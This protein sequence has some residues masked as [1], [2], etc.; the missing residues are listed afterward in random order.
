LGLGAKDTTTNGRQEMS[1]EHMIYEATTRQIAGLELE[2][3]AHLQ[4]IKALVA[5]RDA[6]RERVR[7]LETMLTAARD[8]LDRCHQLFS[9]G[10]GQP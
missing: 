5:E 2:R 10:E 7:E 3:E 6:L 4:Q 9:E 1:N 8:T